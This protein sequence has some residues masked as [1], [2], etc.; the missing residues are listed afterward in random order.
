MTPPT[1]PPE[2]SAILEARATVPPHVVYRD[3]VSEVVVLNLQ[4]GRYHGLNPTGGRFLSALERAE[5]VRDAA[6]AL[7]AEF[8][9]PLEEVERDVV[10]LCADLHSRG[11]IELTP[12]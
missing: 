2:D 3:L 12:A 5:T 1:T 6:T 4:T 7:A 11:L 10:E 8:S 9:S